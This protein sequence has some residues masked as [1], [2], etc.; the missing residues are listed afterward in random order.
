MLIESLDETVDSQSP[1]IDFDGPMPLLLQFPLLTQ[2]RSITEK[3][4]ADA[5]ARSDDPERLLLGGKEWA[6]V[7]VQGSLKGIG[8][9][10]V[11][12]C[13]ARNILETA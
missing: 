1:F 5:L 7:Q 2:Q 6:P 11:G 4:T 13:L 10:G 3:F 9:C 12:L 8:A